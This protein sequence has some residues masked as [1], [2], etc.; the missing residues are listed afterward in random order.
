[1]AAPSRRST[2]LAPLAALLL[3]ACGPPF[4]GG[5][6]GGAGPTPADPCPDEGACDADCRD[7]VG[8]PGACGWRRG[9]A[10]CV[11]G[12]RPCDA[13]ACYAVEAAREACGTTPAG[14]PVGACL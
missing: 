2:L 8:L 13:G 9:E 14:M 3:A 10:T 6:A 1:M 11:C 5:G 12:P 7:G 4:E